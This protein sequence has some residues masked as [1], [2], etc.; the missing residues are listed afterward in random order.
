M[1]KL[2]ASV[3]VFIASVVVLLS[4]PF[5]P[6]VVCIIGAAGL[7]AL[8][9][10]KPPQAIA[11]M[12]F[13]SLV[14]YVYQLGLP[15]LVFVGMAIF[16]IILSAVSDSPGAATGAAAGVI[17]GMLTLTP[18][19]FLSLPVIMGVTIFRAKGQKVGST[20]SLMLFLLLYLPL[21]TNNLSISSHESV[22]PLFQ[23][24]NYQ[25]KEPVSL[26]EVGDMV[27]ALVKEV[28]TNKIIWH[29]L[30]VYL[31]IGFTDYG[32]RLLGIILAV[33]I[34]MSVSIA[35]ALRSVFNWMTSR[36]IRIPHLR[37]AAPIAS[38]LIAS[39][40][41]LLLLE[42][43]KPSFGYFTGLDGS[44]LGGLL[45]GTV[46]V[47]G[48]GSATE[49]WLRR[50]DQLI[51][52]REEL[53]EL[54]PSITEK[55]DAL[56]ARL[57]STRTRSTKLGLSSE[58]ALVAKCSQ[59]L[60]FV[61]SIEHMDLT[62]LQRKL[63]V[64]KDLEVQINNAFQ[65]T[66]RKLTR[67]YTEGRLRYNDYLQQSNEIGFPS[68]DPI[69]EAGTSV[70]A[71]RWSPG[72]L[73]VPV[74][75]ITLEATATEAMSSGYEGILK[76]QE[77]LNEKLG[78]LAQVLMKEC[79]AIVQVIVTE[80]DSTLMTGGVEIARNY[81]NQGHC[82]DAVDTLLTVLAAMERNIRA[83]TASFSQRI[84]DAS[85]GLKTILSDALLP[86]LDVMGDEQGIMHLND[87]VSQIGDLRQADANEKTFAQLSRIVSQGKRLAE[88]SHSVFSWVAAK[89]SELEKDIEV[90]VP[91]GHSWGKE[92]YALSETEE[93]IA[94]LD[95]KSG[96]QNLETRVATIENIEKA[97]GSNA[98]LM[99]QYAST[100][101][102]LINYVNIEYLLDQILQE[103]G[104]AEDKDLPV[105]SV[106]ALRYLKLYY[107]KRYSE[108]TLNATTKG[109]SVRL[110][111]ER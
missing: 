40:V 77:N 62:T 6:P 8:A 63:K 71:T 58:Q 98:V 5:F 67:Y 86:K 12:L 79:D 19:Y 82:E 25:A 107:E 90:R 49:L 96:K 16:Y 85:T 38:L 31:P 99:D 72:A 55:N 68:G 52:L 1:Q 73:S 101:E 18:F 34:A 11:I 39:G 28:G 102:F 47:G 54:L 66:L 59:E 100:L 60:S 108:V 4:V 75:D 23:Q 41:F 3:A 7:A 42:T 24:V 87:I 104:C 10:G 26:V 78:Q 56:K 9:F 50:R 109:L 14:G 29:N 80:I 15:V 44:A 97:I 103:R 74:G 95:G 37:L 92:P 46:V 51:T 69:S 35:F 61:S 110:E 57:E 105:R 53:S 43:L 76:E 91:R 21:L 81:L 36:E 83:P 33:V 64:L 32:S 93:S 17:A 89:I 30:T 70:S 2:L 84:D 111:N 22:V 106:F 20:I 27:S 48:M 45:L 88:L 94:K 65:E 13:A